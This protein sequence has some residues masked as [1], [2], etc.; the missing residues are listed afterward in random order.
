MIIDYF[1]W[2]IA[3]IQIET[4]LKSSIYDRTESSTDKKKIHKERDMYI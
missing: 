4:W 2:L 3:L 1:M